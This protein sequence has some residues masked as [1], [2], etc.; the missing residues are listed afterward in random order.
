MMKLNL[1]KVKTL[2]NRSKE[3]HLHNINKKIVKRA[4]TTKAN[5]Q[6]LIIRKVKISNFI[7]M[8]RVV[9]HHIFDRITRKIRII[10]EKSKIQA[11][12]K[13]QKRRNKMKRRTKLID[14]LKKTLI[15]KMNKI[16][17]LIKLHPRTLCQCHH[18]VE[19]SNRIAYRLVRKN[20]RNNNKKR[21]DNKEV[22]IRM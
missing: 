19:K 15:L 12:P 8:I 7:L 4:T 16:S 18:L 21:R 11:H 20:C 3:T 14:K 2:S 1:R 17:S 10:M 13:L 5:N 9:S 6:L 22:A